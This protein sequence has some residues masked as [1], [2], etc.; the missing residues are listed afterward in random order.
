[1]TGGCGDGKVGGGV[2]SARAY[3]DGFN[4]GYGKR[5]CREGD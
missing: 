5:G 1:M 2:F 3:V 4:E